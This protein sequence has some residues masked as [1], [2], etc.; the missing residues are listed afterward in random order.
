MSKIRFAVIVFFL[1]SSFSI[2]QNR[3]ID[4]LKNNLILT[5]ENT[6]KVDILNDL[7]W[8]YSDSDPERSMEYATQAQSLAE[9]LNYK[10]GLSSAYSNEASFYRDKSNYPEAMKR[11]LKCLQLKKEIND[12]P[13]LAST[14]TNIGIVYKLQGNYKEVLSYYLLSLKTRQQVGSQKEIA[15]SYNNI[16]NLF[17]AQGEFDKALEY[18]FSALKTRKQI[19]DKKG[20]AF[21]YNNI[22]GITSD[23]GSYPKALQYYYRSLKLLEELDNKQAISLVCTNIGDIY[24]YQKKYDEAL[25]W[26]FKSLE[27]AKKLDNKNSIASSYNAIGTIYDYKKN[28]PKAL[29]FYIQ[30]LNIKLEI[31]DKPGIAESYNNIGLIY[32][33]Q[34]QYDGA[35]N[36]FFKALKI[37]EEMG[38]KKGLIST[39]NNIGSVLSIQNKFIRAINYLSKA[40]TL[41]KNVGANDM[42]RDNYFIFAE[43]YAHQK[44]FSKAYEYHLLYTQIKDSL[45]NTGNSL[46]LSELQT[47]YE[48]E[49]K[50]K[51]IIKLKQQQEIDGLN[52]SKQMLLVQKRNYMIAIIFAIIFAIIIISYLL[53]G[54]YKILQKQKQ[55]N[56]I[57]DTEQKERVRIAKDIHDELGSGLSKIALIA[58]FSKQHFNGNKQLNDNISSISKTSTD[59]MNNMRDLVW[60]LNP[61]NT[62]LD[63]LVA[64]I[65]EYSGEYMEEIPIKTEFHFPEEVPANKIT[66]EAQ[67]TIFLTFKE[68]LNNSV[69]HSEA[70]KIAVTL[71]LYN[72]YLVIIIEDNGKGFDFTNIKKTGNGLHN[73]KQRIEAIDGIY[74]IQTGLDSGTTIKLIIPLNKI[75]ITD[76]SKVLLS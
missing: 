20:M 38:D 58:E 48:T 16:G 18:H 32:K 61:E 29:S 69:K 33:Y 36:Y 60:A 54:R 19:K 65:Y 6:L 51:E 24:V 35:L 70:S 40:L 57:I 39:Y 62:T 17:W 22:G 64:R 41:A 73:M 55:E 67:R 49:K 15:D 37:K 42:L 5:K 47:K 46:Q 68:A 52:I 71:T 34:K 1:M 14:Y 31:G 3:T 76:N 26:F 27:M 43:T 25:K 13:G 72:N 53:F 21:S 59:L 12:L 2:A 44:I 8:E 74:S 66:K 28:Y 4:S 9:K 45:L 10:K 23:K 50:E 30:S 7:S 11:Y 56:A 75:I 63:N